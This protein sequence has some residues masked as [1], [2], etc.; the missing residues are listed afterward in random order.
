MIDKILNHPYHYCGAV[1]ARLAV[2]SATLIWALVVMVEQNALAQTR[3]GA[4]LTAVAG[5]NWIAGMF[6][7]LALGLIF[8]IF[9]PSPPN[10]WGILAYLA[11]ALLWIYADIMI[12]AVRPWQPTSIAW[13]SVG[14]VLA[15]Y[16][17]VANP[18]PGAR[19]AAG[20]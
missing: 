16:A 3:Y 15:A 17:L 12:L 6:G 14:S 20:I 13:C 1:I 11:L 5:E 2:C 8:R 10:P 7:V 19:C 4:P 18:R 9:R